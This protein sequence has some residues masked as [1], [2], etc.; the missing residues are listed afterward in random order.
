[1]IHVR[2]EH[3]ELHIRTES[4]GY[5]SAVS[6]VALRFDSE[7]MEVLLDGTILINGVQP[8]TLPSTLDGI[9]PLEVTSNAAK[10]L[11]SGGQYI[12]IRFYYNNLLVRIDAHGS[13]FF[14]S[15]GMAGTWNTFGLIGRDG[16]TD[17]SDDTTAFAVEWEVSGNDPLL[18]STPALSLCN[19]TTLPPA[20]PT[21]EEIANAEEICGQVL[22]EGQENQVNCVFDV[23]AGGGDPTWAQNPAYTEPLVSTERCV[24]AG[25]IMPSCASL[26]GECVYRCD[27][28]EYD[29][30]I[31]SYCQ[32]NADLTVVDA[33]RRSRR[34]MEF[35]EGCSCAL[36]K[37]P[38]D[39]PST[40][41]SFKPSELPSV[42]PS[43]MPTKASKKA[44]RRR[45]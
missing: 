42:F 27:S 18:F 37:Q 19:G 25:G 15:V 28:S 14:E 1:M 4:R 38:S 43:A 44:K 7:V 36:P 41:A 26:G 34:R 23:L 40:V 33:A 8:A 17:Y 13:D 20:E 21:A 6:R 45:L 5:W 12:E 39:A 24:E 11:M 10:V 31:G 35:V 16:I 22:L 29:C 3:L 2:N 9:Y 32:D 30:L